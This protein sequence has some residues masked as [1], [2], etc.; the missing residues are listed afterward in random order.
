MLTW[1]GNQVEDYITQNHLEC[2]QYAYHARILNQIWYVSGIIHTVIGIEFFW[3]F[4]IQPAV[5]YNYTDGKIWCL[6]KDVNKTKCI[7]PYMESH[8][9][10]TG[11]TTVHLSDKKS[12][13]YVVDENIVTPKVKHTTIPV[14]FLQEQYGNGIFIPK[15]DKYVTMLEGICTKTFLGTIIIQSIKLMTGF[16]F[17]PPNNSN[18]YQIMVL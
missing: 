17:Y 15:Y 18:H 8:A 2:K 10:H 11:S 4:Q 16:W 13:I 7:R 3:K 6:Y 1:I 14:F 9:L 5:V 12:C